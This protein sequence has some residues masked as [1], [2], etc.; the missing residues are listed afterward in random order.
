MHEVPEGRSDTEAGEGDPFD[1]APPFELDGR[2]ILARAVMNALMQGQ[3]DPENFDFSSAVFEALKNVTN[4][5][6]GPFEPSPWLCINLEDFRVGRAYPYRGEHRIVAI[7]PDFGLMESI[8]EE[9]S[10]E[11]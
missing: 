4:N 2:D 5:N 3:R 7:T 6:V 9:M 11:E 8:D 1:S 10:D